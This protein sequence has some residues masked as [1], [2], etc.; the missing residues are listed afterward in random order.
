MSDFID[1][2][3]DL[4]KDLTDKA[5]GAVGDHA[6]TIEGGIDKAAKFVDEK[7]KGKYADKIETVQAKAHEAVEKLAAGKGQDGKGG[8]ETG[9]EPRSDGGGT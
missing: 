2:A 4:A 3:K 9:D 8:G 7:T 5:R 6:D 1:K